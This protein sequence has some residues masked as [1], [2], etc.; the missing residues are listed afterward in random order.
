MTETP[1]DSARLEQL[2]PRTLLLD[3]NSRT[4]G[5]LETED[6]DLV[7]SIRRH[8]VKVPVL[9][10]RVDAD[11]V[12]VL[13][14]HSRTIAASLAIS[15][16][17][18]IPVLITDITGEQEW[19]LLRD[20]WI[21]NEVRR[22]YSPADK[23][24]IMEK[25]TLFGLT[26]QDVAEQLSTTPEVVEA[27]LAVRRSTRASELTRVHPQLDVLQLAAVAEFEDDAAASATLDTTLEEEPEQFDH[28]VSR[29]R[30]HRA[31]C[32][33]RDIRVDELRATGVTVLDQVDPATTLALSR[34]L[35][36]KQDHTSLGDNPDSHTD[37]PGHA[38]LVSVSYSEVQVKY[39]C[40]DWSSY[41][42]L[43]AW[44]SHSTTATEV[45]GQLSETEKAERRRVRTNNEAWRAAQDVRRC[46]LRTTLFA[47]KK[48]PKRAQQYL[49]LALA[50]GGQHLTQAM[51]RGNRYACELLGLR[52]PQWGRPSPIAARAKRAAGDQA[53]MMGIA[54]MVGAFEEALEPKASVDTWRRPTPEDRLYFAALKDWGY[55]LSKV[56]RLVLD[57]TADAADWTH[58]TPTAQDDAENRAA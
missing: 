6:P 36:S 23:A 43:D 45:R 10:A 47:A 22:G 54:V 7:A 24:R 30:H 27:G 32:A 49:L 18:T 31:A 26:T 25:L 12:R 48:P 41:G 15:E 29:L 8:G 1:W 11:T 4:I 51:G 19:E 53:L 35:V 17:P 55:V 14:G 16:H 5:D 34:L 40:Q 13:D 37:C 21:A 2:D 50:E 52:E 20:Q 33:E 38:A 46:W 3:Y 42:H 57:P 58:L 39:V 44:T 28:V 9:A 56:E